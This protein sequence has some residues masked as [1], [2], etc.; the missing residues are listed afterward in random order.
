M[1]KL[2][3]L[4]M[5]AS[6]FAFSSCKDDDENLSVSFEKLQ[7]VDVEVPDT[8]QL[9]RSYEIFVT[10]TRPNACTYFQGF[11][12]YKDEITVRNVTPVGA[13]Y[14]NQ[15]CTQEAVEV[16]D[17]FWFKVIYDQNYTFRF[18]TGEDEEGNAEFIEKQVVVEPYSTD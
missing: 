6:L 17:S 3:Y 12:V 1:K 5:I 15:E 7:I 8:F 4:G 14:T 13:H 9:G 10:Y 2:F 16:T 18:W 11:D